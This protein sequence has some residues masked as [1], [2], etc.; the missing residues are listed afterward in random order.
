MIEITE[1]G[2]IGTPPDREGSIH[3]RPLIGKVSLRLTRWLRAIHA[4]RYMDEGELHIDIGCGDGYF[5]FRSPYKRRVGFDKLMGDDDEITDR[6]SFPDNSVDLV[7]ML[8]VI[9]HLHDPM[10]L[11]TEIHRV[12]KPGHKLILTT[13]KE[14]AERIIN[15]Y[16]KHIDE[17]HEIYFDQESMK[18]LVE[19]L[20]Q[21]THYHTFIVG[22]NQAFCLTKLPK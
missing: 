5:L 17:V 16:V 10:T 12:L 15:L 18:E 11:L 14:A 9:E 19:G 8:A 3:K 20:F 22:L 7:T 2:L 13:P 6:L 21:V 4:E 1:A